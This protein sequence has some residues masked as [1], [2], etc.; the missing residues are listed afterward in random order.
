MA[1]PDV[2]LGGDVV[3]RMRGRA[4]IL[5]TG[6]VV[7][8][9]LA[10]I[11]GVIPGLRRAPG[12]DFYQALVSGQATVFGFLIIVLTVVFEQQRSEV[13]ASLRSDDGTRAMIVSLATLS[14]LVSALGAVLSLTL[15]S[16][17][18]ARRIYGI[19][20]GA[21]T[22]SGLA[23]GLAAIAVLVASLRPLWA[24]D[25]LVAGA[26][27]GPRTRRRQQ[28]QDPTEQRGIVASDFVRAVEQLSRLATIDAESSNFAAFKRRIDGLKELRRTVE[29]RR[30]ADEG[31]VHEEVVDPVADALFVL[32]GGVFGRRDFALHAIAALEEALGTEM[33]YEEVAQAVDRLVA[34]LRRISTV[35]GLSARVMRA[36]VRAPI[37]CASGQHRAATRP[38]IHEALYLATAE[39][40][41]RDITDAAIDGISDLLGEE[42]ADITS[43]CGAVADLKSRDSRDSRIGDGRV[44]DAAGMAVRALHRAHRG[45][46]SMAVVSGIL[47]DATPLAA[48]MAMVGEAP[49]VHEMASEILTS[50]VA[51][52]FADKSAAISASRHGDPP[53]ADGIVDAPLGLWL[54]N[55][56]T[57]WREQMLSRWLTVGVEDMLL[58]EAEQE[59][60]STYGGRTTESRILATQLG[61][62]LVDLD[63]DGAASGR[64]IDWYRFSD[65]LIGM[66]RASVTV[67]DRGLHRSAIVRER[68]HLLMEHGPEAIRRSKLAD[69]LFVVASASSDAPESPSDRWQGAPEDPADVG[70]W[71]RHLV[72]RLFRADP[73][74]GSV[75]LRSA[76][77]DAELIARAAE[78]FWDER[79]QRLTTCSTS[80]AM[81]ALVVID[82]LERDGSDGALAT[83]VTTI[84]RLGSDA[85]IRLREVE[86]LLDDRLVAVIDRSASTEPDGDA[87]PFLML[88]AACA[89][90]KLSSDRP[91]FDDSTVEAAATAI[92]T[93]VEPMG[94]E[95]SDRRMHPSLDTTWCLLPPQIWDRATLVLSERPVD[96]LLAREFGG[97]LLRLGLPSG[98]SALAAS[99]HGFWLALRSKEIAEARGRSS[100]VIAQSGGSD[101]SFLAD[102][103]RTQE[104]T[105]DPHRIGVVHPAWFEGSGSWPVDVGAGTLVLPEA[106]TRFQGG[107]IVIA[108]LSD[109]DEEA[110]Q[111]HLTAPEV[112]RPEDLK[113]RLRELHGAHPA[114][115]PRVVWT[116]P[117][118]CA[119]QGSTGR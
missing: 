61:S 43:L 84:A 64:T 41:P 81:I 67:D 3:S 44:S 14:V 108:L 58:H 71:L 6:I 118:P 4:Q 32:V 51:K 36:I 49:A 5:W 68:L 113:A 60:I 17:P 13:E 119:P 66:M 78:R 72:P 40:A 1:S 65:D 111:G 92:V 90:M 24:T 8:A 33:G 9:S 82:L 2:R 56:P 19:L 94:S 50:A 52:A 99:V 95:S 116:I 91:Q 15:V 79:S 76:P 80:E 117:L 45:S 93:I 106:S 12:A 46:R 112:V 85:V 89:C 20:T 21:L 42:A 70:Q 30:S 83:F 11:L 75:G 31:S 53:N 28:A 96:H 88:L 103:L 115:E 57:P 63:V 39:L 114:D 10:A 107:E 62:A 102:L 77:L 97:R 59:V 18:P 22:A 109:R 16:N 35:G 87:D 26:L 55:I 98:D 74:D 110:P 54:R 34:L 37:R 38:L 48:L 69:A 100:L 101:R 47:T 25:R 73:S 7:A 104:R 86:P 27:R 23:L 29:D 105:S